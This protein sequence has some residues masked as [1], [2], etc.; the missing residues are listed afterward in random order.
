MGPDL[1]SVLLLGAWFLVIWIASTFNRITVAHLSRIA[2]PRG[3]LCYNCADSISRTICVAE[4]GMTCKTLLALS[5][6]GSL[7][8]TGCGGSSGGVGSTNTASPTITSVSVFGT[9]LPPPPALRI[10]L[11]LK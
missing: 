4:A 3:A 5:L 10:K 9:D 8:V 2:S 11:M 1:R 7:Y 6:L